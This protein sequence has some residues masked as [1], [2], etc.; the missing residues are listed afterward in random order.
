VLET[1]R[2]DVPP[3]VEPEFTAHVDLL[4]CRY[5]AA[6]AAQ[7]YLRR[8]IA[9]FPTLHL[10]EFKFRVIQPVAVDQTIV[11]EYPVQLEDVPERINR[12]IFTRISKDISVS[13]GSLVA[14]MVNTDDV[15][16]FGRVQSGLQA[17]KVA[18][19]YLSRGLYRDNHRPAGE[20]VEERTDE[21]P[22]RALYRAWARLMAAA[23]ANEV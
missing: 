13:S 14:G 12:A 19:L 23:P 7:I 22:Q 11:Y 10:M 3:E 20:V 4:K 17:A 18:W 9:I 2:N 8:H 21:V 6:A 5:G 16:I 1:E 15:E